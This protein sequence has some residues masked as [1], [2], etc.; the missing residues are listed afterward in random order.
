A[1]RHGQQS[2]A[3]GTLHARPGG[4]STPGATPAQRS[5]G[6]LQS[7]LQ[8]RAT[9]TPRPS[10]ADLTPCRGTGLS[11]FPLHARGSRSGFRSPGSA[12][13]ATVA[14]VRKSLIIFSRGQWISFPR[15]LVPFT[16]TRRLTARANSS[17][18]NLEG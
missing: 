1:A 2:H 18:A 17:P 7:R 10:P 14:R 11:R 12:L 16:L 3:Q 8:L 4:R 15:A 5:V 9:Q 13:S 6:P